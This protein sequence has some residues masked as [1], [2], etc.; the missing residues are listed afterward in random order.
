MKGENADFS[1]A[2]SAM[3]DKLGV[4]D[5]KEP[6]GYTWHHHQDGITMELVPSALHN[7]VPHTGG[8]SLARDPGY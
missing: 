3:A 5:W 7:N 8:A 4:K 2:R 1:A 6:K